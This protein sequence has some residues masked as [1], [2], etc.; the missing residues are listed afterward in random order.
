MINLPRIKGYNSAPWNISIADRLYEIKTAKK[1]NKKI[2]I[3]IYNEA[4]TST[5][6]YRCYNIYQST[7]R[8]EVWQAVYF[9]FEELAIV[10]NFLNDINKI[11]IVRMKWTVKLDN[12]I[13]LAKS[14]KISVLFDI[15]DRVFDTKYLNVVTNTLAIEIE[16]ESAYDFWFAYISRI[17]LTASLCDGFIVTNNFLGKALSEK[18]QKPYSVIPNFLNEE[19]I[20]VSNKLC[21]QKKANM[22]NLKNKLFS[23]GYFSGTPSHINDFLIVYKEIMELLH[24]YDDIR[25]DVVGF[26]EFPVEIQPLIKTGRVTFTHLVDFVELQ[27]LIAQVDVNIVPLVRND[28]TNCKS[29]LKFF[30]AAIVD[31]ITVATP[32]YTYK[33]SIEHGVTGYLCNQGE[34][35]G[36]IE[37][38]YKNKFENITDYTKQYV[39]HKYFGDEVKKQI[40]EAYN[41]NI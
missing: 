18:F 22:G 23:L 36:C 35:Y 29:E 34:W 37:N 32:T 10:E 9:F 33:N 21:A 13:T 40:E 28:F 3:L 41:L 31:T 27:R 20:S 1:N 16:N 24:K 6:R 38:I 7:K 5:F 17:E 39:I 11:I 8:S 2:A 19:Q 14:R 25:L 12:F 30:E 15:D 4:D 26:M